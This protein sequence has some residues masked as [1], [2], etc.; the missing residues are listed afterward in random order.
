[1]RVTDDLAAHIPQPDAA[2]EIAN[3]LGIAA[4]ESVPLAGPFLAA[5]PQSAL[6]IRQAQERAKF[7]GMVVAALRDLDAQIN[8]ITPD[9]LESTEF[10]AAYTKAARAA[11][12]TASEKKRR[13]LARALA[14]MGPWST[15]DESWRQQLFD[16]V[17][18]YD[19]LHVQLL[20][21]FRD[22][23][24]WIRRGTPDYQEGG[25]GMGGITGPLAT[26]M[27][28]GYVDWQPIV[29][30]AI[31]TLETDGT[32]QVP[33]GSSMTTRGTVE[34][35]TTALGDALFDFIAEPPEA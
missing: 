10:V 19:D 28:P 21:Y 4:L 11:A 12:E 18:G 26:Y 31:R 24:G 3:A 23:V 14:Q 13:R 5:G 6:A 25:F 22:P 35:R 2:Q 8:A 32:A 29:L 33:L 9:M 1:V 30:P 27:F 17:A 34:K 20:D 16:L 7:D 15:L